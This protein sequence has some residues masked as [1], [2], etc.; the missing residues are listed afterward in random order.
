MENTTTAPEQIGELYDSMTRMSEVFNEGQEHLAYWYGPDDDADAVTAGLRLTRKVTDALG[1][2]RGEHLLD[3][4]CGVGAPGVMVA[5]ETGVQVTG[6]TVSRVEAAVAEKR[7]H[8]NDLVGQ[9]RFQH[10]NYE[11]MPFADGTFDAVMA[12]ESLTHATDLPAAL[13]E[14]HRVL[15]PGGRV[16][17]SECTRA[18]GPTGE[19]VA[20]MPDVFRPNQLLTTHE[21]VR[22]LE[23][24]GFAV[25]EYTQ[26]GP[27]VYGLGLRY[28]DR[29]NELHD[30]LTQEFGPDAVAS[31]K[32]GYKAMFGGDPKAMGYAVVTARKPVVPASAA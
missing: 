2:R 22:A 21:W 14:F 5:R 31:L 4:G 13:R 16:A 20:S 19:P 9:V 28:L 26:C 15:R 1:L 23:D 12:I 32:Q 8:D 18:V 3:A 10:G 27:R 6:I 11:K 24:A 17:L 30:T 7:V 29:A 25:E